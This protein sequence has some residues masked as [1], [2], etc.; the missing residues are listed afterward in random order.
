MRPKVVIWGAAG[1]AMV[2]ADIIRLRGDYEL[3]G[4]LDDVNCDRAGTSFYDARVLGGREQLSHLRGQGVGFLL[5]AFGNSVV[6]LA[7][8]DLVRSKGFE[9]ATAV[10]PRAVVSPGAR[11]GAGTVIK[12]GAVIDPDVTI[13]ENVMIGACACVGHGSVLGDGAR[14]SAGASL[15]GNVS[16][17]RATMIGAGAAI[18]DRICIG[19]HVIIGAGSIVVQD[20]PDGVVAYG[21]PARVMR[22]IAP[23][24]Y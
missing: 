15:P 11:I 6:R 24:D 8:T 12:A 3:V 17:G 20:I 7:L 13:G 1:Q 4:F 2:V 10:H 18:R 22:K 21:V 19:E 23:D 9:L 16:I 5:F 14:I